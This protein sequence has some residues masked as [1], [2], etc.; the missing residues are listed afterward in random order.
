M[1][2]ADIADE[3]GKAL[4]DELGRSAIFVHHDVSDE[5]SWQAAVDETVRD[6]RPGRPC[7]STTPAS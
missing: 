6:V 7:W 5:D 2:I 3:P 4:A 1:V